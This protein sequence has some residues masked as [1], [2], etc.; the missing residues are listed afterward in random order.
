MN[1]IFRDFYAKLY[2]ADAPQEDHL[3]KTFVDQIELP[4][5]TPTQINNLNAPISDT[6]LEDTIKGLMIGKPP[7]PD[8]FTLTFYKMFRKTLLPTQQS[9]YQH[10]GWGTHPTHWERKLCKSFNKKRQEYH[11]PRILSS[12]L[13]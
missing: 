2:T 11:P 1:E 4:T 13:L 10:M 3:A 6:E 7:G 12:N 8:G 9:I 5:L